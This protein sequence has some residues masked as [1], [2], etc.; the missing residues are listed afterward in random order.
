[1]DGRSSTLGCGCVPPAFA[2]GFDERAIECGNVVGLPAEDEL[3]VCD[4]LLI[5]PGGACI[6]EISFQRW[7]RRD[8]LVSQHSR[9]E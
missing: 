9:L 1:M 2:Y 5:H 3:P 7:P 6:F 4:N 8:G